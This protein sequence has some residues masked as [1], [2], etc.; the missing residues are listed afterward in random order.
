MR[1]LD[2]MKEWPVDN[3]AATVLADG[4]EYSSGEDSRI[5]DLA[6][7]TKLVAAYGFLMAMEEGVFELDTPLGPEAPRFVIFWRMP[8]GWALMIPSRSASPGSVESTPPRVS[9]SSLM[10]SAP[11]RGCRSLSICWKVSSSR[12]G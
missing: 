5:Y 7:V 3:A 10:R 4:T 8:P 6:S 2:Q 9:R 12:W 11:R 1:S